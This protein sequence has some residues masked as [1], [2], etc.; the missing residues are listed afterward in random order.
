MLQ[1]TRKIFAARLIYLRKETGLTQ[2]ELSEQIGINQTQISKM[3]NAQTLPKWSSLVKIRS[4]FDCSYDFLLS[5]NNFP[6]ETKYIDAI[7]KINFPP[8]KDIEIPDDKA[9]KIIKIIEKVVSEILK[10]D[11]E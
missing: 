10:T 5:E 1:K 4:F 3:E 11:A 9:E 2:E 7:S 6:P 8:P